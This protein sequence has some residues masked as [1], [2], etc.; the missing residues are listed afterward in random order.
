MQSVFLKT[1]KIQECGKVDI[2]LLTEMTSKTE[3]KSEQGIVLKILQGCND[4]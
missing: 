4:L 2:T 1:I 3:G